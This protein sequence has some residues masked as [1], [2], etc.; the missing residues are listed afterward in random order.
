MRNDHSMNGACQNFSDFRSQL[1]VLAARGR[2]AGRR[3]EGAP[4]SGVSIETK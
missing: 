4:G 3:E 2:G 1:R